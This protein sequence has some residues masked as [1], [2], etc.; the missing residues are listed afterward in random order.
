MWRIQIGGGP[1]MPVSPAI[2]PLDWAAWAMVAK[3]I[4]FVE[5]GTNSEPTVSLYDFSTRA[6]QQLTVLDNPPFWVTTTQDGRSVI[7]DHPG[8]EESH[9]MLLENFR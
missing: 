7:F 2:R 1:E 5:S 4:V 6:V 3:G 8:Q 9:V